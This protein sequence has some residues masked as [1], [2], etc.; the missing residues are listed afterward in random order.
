MER[1]AVRGCGAERR[2]EM[3]ERV[4]PAARADGR[5]DA[6]LP[7]H[8]RRR[9]RGVKVWLL[10]SPVPTSQSRVHSLL[11]RSDCSRSIVPWLS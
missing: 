10:C 7:H 11:F 6:T 3:E 8:K 2:G 1:D 9:S 5:G 4:P